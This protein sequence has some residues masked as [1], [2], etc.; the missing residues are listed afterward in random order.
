MDNLK[1][2][3]I[4]TDCEDINK[5]HVPFYYGKYIFKITYD[6]SDLN[7]EEKEKFITDYIIKIDENKLYELGLDDDQIEEY[8][9]PDEIFSINYYD[10]NKGNYVVDI[11]TR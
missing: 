6:K 9:D 10:D 3:D 1:I 11:T 2:I 5:D 4:N 7:K 8:R